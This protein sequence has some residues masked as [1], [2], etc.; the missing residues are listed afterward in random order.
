MIPI[1]SPLHPA[2][3]H[4][5]IVL[6]L[7]GAPIAV[8]AALLPKWHLP[9]LAAALLVAGSLGAIAATWTGGQDEELLGELPQPAEQILEEHEEWGATTRNISIAAA[10]LA[11]LAAALFRH[12]RTSRVLAVFAAITAVGAAFAVSQAGHYG[13]L[14][15]YKHGAGVNTTSSS[16]PDT[17]NRTTSEK[18]PGHRGEDD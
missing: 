16:G 13:G 18:K 7:L 10:I 3:V 6:L 8:I 4:F 2:V 11:S 9:R 5:P 1:P 12:P 15:V 14:L 17:Q